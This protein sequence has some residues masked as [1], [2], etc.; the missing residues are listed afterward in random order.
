VNRGQRFILGLYTLLFSLAALMLSAAAAGWQLPLSVL[1]VLSGNNNE[2]RLVTGLGG[3]LIFLLGIKALMGVG[4]GQNRNQ[5]LVARGE[6]GEVKVTATAI[7]AV[8][9]RTARET[10]GVREVKTRLRSLGTGVAL[11]LLV[12]VQP[13]IPVP[14]L[15]AELQKRVKENVESIIGV[16]VA[17]VRVLVDNIPP[18]ENKPRPRVE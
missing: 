10:N 11:F 4:G 12:V 3:L 7:E 14:A 6:L 15:T 1:G 17:E 13:D 2:V 18:A 5:T 16:D 8:V 9:T